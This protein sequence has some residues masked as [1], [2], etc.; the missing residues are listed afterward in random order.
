M[1]RLTLTAAVILRTKGVGKV[2][3]KFVALN[4][5]SAEFPKGAIT[6]II[7]PNGAGKST[8]FNLLS[9]RVAADQRQ[10]RIR[11]PRRHRN[12]AASLRPYGRRQIVPDHQ[13]VSA[14][15]D[16]R[17]YPRR[18]AGAGVALRHVASARQA[19]RTG[20]AGRRIAGAGRAVGIARAARQRRW[21]MA[22]SARW[23][24]AWRWRAGRGCCCWTSRPPA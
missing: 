18:T 21:R 9:G 16:P 6:S 24:S 2:F 10:R 7:G 12:A 22:S 8:Y 17:E 14:T 4:N 5:I 19:A 3:G 23:K 11:G 1:S 15:D 20:R 13:R